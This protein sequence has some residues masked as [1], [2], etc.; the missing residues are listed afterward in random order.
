MP[1]SASTELKFEPTFA[2]YLRLQQLIGRAIWPSARERFVRLLTFVGVGMLISFASSSILAK[3]NVGPAG[4]K[5]YIA[6]IMT[7]IVLSMAMWFTGTR[8]GLRRAFS[9]IDPAS[10]SAAYDMLGLTSRVGGLVFDAPWRKLSA[11]YVAGDSTYVAFG[12]LGGAVL[13]DRAFASEE[14]RDAFRELIAQHVTVLKI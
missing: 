7:G 11:A 5:V 12:P 13:P 1:D 9:K 3:F 4:S 14:Q 2:E 8:D 6:G 10:W